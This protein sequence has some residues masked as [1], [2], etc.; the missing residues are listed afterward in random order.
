MNQWTK[1]TRKSGK[2]DNRP[3]VSIRSKQ[4][5]FNAYFVS[6][7][8]IAEKSQVSISLN[9]ELFQVGFRFHNDRM[10]ED[11]YSLT[12][13]GGVILKAGEEQFKFVD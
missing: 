5:A 8:N 2:S 3:F 13:D 1:Y 12:R 4:I 7:A 10:K 9:P 11:S 6:S